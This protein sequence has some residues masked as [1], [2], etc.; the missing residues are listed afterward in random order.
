[1]GNRTGEWDRVLPCP[2]CSTEI[3][4]EDITCPVCGYF[5]PEEDEEA[6]LEEIKNERE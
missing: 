1:M 5:I 6:G 4:I 3:A 2:K